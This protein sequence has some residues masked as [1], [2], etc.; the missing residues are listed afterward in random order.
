MR[1]GHGGHQALAL[2]LRFSLE[3]RRE[4]WTGVLKAGEGQT[5]LLSS[6][7]SQS[8]G[9]GGFGVKSEGDFT[10]NFHFVLRNGASSSLAHPESHFKS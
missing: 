5:W 7:C 1:S 6:A 4:A 2:E 3:G 8:V 10:L 9:Q